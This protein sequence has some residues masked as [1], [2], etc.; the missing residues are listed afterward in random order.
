MVYVCYSARAEIGELGP[1]YSVR[2]LHAVVRAGRAI[3]F[4]IVEQRQ[5]MLERLANMPP[6][7]PYA[8]DRRFES[9]LYV[10]ESVGDW[11]RK[12]MQLRTA[13]QYKDHAKDVKFRPL[14]GAP[15]ADVVSTSGDFG[16]TL[17]AY[18]NALTAM[19]DQL[20]RIDGV[21]DTAAA[22]AHFRM[23]WVV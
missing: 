19:Y 5:Q 14:A 23:E 15:S 22:E 10:S 6:D 9:G 18:Q 21:F 17:V 1:W 8:R 11:G 7:E 12:F 16:D 3:N 20:S 13:L 2:T 4:S